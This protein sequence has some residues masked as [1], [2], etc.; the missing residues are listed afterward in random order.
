M[1]NTLKFLLE[2]QEYIDNI[3]N[4]NKD[5]YIYDEIKKR[6][7]FDR[8]T[9]VEG[10]ILTYP[11]DKS[12]NIL[13]KRFPELDIQVETDGDIFIQGFTNKIDKYL[14]LI[15]N[16]GYFISKITI[17]G[18]EWKIDFKNDDKP[19]AIYLEPKYDYEV[20]IP[21][22]LYHASPIKFKD[23][24]LKF[25]LSPRSGNKLSK[26]PE[27]IYLTDNL[28]NAIYF[29]NYL[30]NKENNDW[31]KN[32]YCI[33]SVNGKA[34]SKLYSDINLREGGYYTLNNINPNDIKLIKEIL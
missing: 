24:I 33:Y 9:L 31:Y 21:D 32:G 1:G 12:V 29:G 16:I 11:I 18:K 7:K 26:H 14:P 28:N 17:D 15:T 5:L 25:G 13:K 30:K 8:L 6:S 27:R 2:Y 3:E 4:S 23:K 22:K 10:L 19:I 34:I 20:P